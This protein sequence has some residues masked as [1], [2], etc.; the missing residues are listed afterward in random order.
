[1][2]ALIIV[3]ICNIVLFVC[4]LFAHKQLAMWERLSKVNVVILAMQEDMLKK[5]GDMLK[6]Q[7][8]MLKK[9]GDMLKKQRDIIVE[10]REKVD[11]LL[12]NEV[13]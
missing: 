9:Q 7:G 4:C 3:F 2:V 11:K 10:L 5:Q 1:M 12:K 8:D 6:K 13:I